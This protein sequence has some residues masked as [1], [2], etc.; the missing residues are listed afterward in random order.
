MEDDLRQ[1]EYLELCKAE[2]KVH[3]GDVE[4]EASGV[5]DLERAVRMYADLAEW[6]EALARERG[7][8]V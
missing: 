2:G 4:W 6:H 5:I 7:S 8:L 1:I 3:R